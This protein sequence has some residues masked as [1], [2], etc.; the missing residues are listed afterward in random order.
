MNQKEAQLIYN[1]VEGAIFKVRDCA[2][3][4]QFI[5]KSNEIDTIY[6]QVL[7]LLE[8]KRMRAEGFLNRK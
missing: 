4:E 1:L 7:R 3:R 5:V 6:A 2:N 8:E